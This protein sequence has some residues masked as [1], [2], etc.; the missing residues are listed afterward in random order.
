[1]PGRYNITPD[2]EFKNAR[3]YFW[4]GSFF[5][6]IPIEEKRLEQ[7]TRRGSVATKDCFRGR[8]VIN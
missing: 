1:M 2:F 7:T 4:C 6:F 8:L 3:A 5:F